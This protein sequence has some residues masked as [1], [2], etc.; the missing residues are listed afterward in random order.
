MD[1]ALTNDSSPL[2]IAIS[3]AHWVWVMD[4]QDSP[5]GSDE[6]LKRALREV[7][8]DRESG[9]DTGKELKPSLCHQLPQMAAARMEVLL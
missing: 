3:E 9:V 4:H 1:F 8:V 7:A 2:I 5:E 6:D